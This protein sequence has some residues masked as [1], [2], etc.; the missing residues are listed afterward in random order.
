M[1][2][3]KGSAEKNSRRMKALNS[4]ISDGGNSAKS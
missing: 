3:E 1:D 4:D 2:M